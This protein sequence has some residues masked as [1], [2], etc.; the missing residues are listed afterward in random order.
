MADNP[1]TEEMV[2]LLIEGEEE[3]GSPHLSALVDAQRARLE[4]DLAVTADGPYHGSGQPLIILGVRGLLFVEASVHGAQRDL[5]SGS[6]GGTAP[7]PARILTRALA[8]LWDAEGHVAVPGFY[9]RVLP[10]TPPESELVAALAEVDADNGAQSTDAAAWRKIMFEPNLNIAGICCGY[11]G[12]GIK[13]IIPHK[14]SAK[15]DVRLVADQDPEQ[16][17]ALL[18]DFLGERGAR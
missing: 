11:T 2:K 18:R 6:N 5:H 13:T 14:A 4:C 16:I 10:P 17:Y 3:I 1:P 15:I 7:A 9:D 8:E 12:P